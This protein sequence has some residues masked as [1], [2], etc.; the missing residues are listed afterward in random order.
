MSANDSDDEVALSADT[1]RALNEFL[2]EKKEKE[3]MLQ[4]AMD[5]DEAVKKINIDEDWQLSQFWY[6]ENTTE[7]LS[8]EAVCRAGKEGSIALISCPTLYPKIRELAPD[9]KVTLFEYDTRFKIYGSDFV[10]YDYK[11]PLDVPRE[12]SAH[13][14]LVVL[15]PPF[16]SDECLTK[17]AVTAKFLAKH[18]ILVCTGEIMQD[19]A[20][21][22]LGVKK[23]KFIPRHKNNLANDFACFVNF[24]SGLS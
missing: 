14:D 16:L 1:L 3:E 21:R 18:D 12:L 5:N 15:D 19:L 8:E 13:Y 7:R 10:F 20:L 23:C 17:A 24:D 4:S 6:D 9:A 22:L 11:A 2:A